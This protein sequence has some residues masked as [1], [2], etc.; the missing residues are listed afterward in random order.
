MHKVGVHIRRLGG[1]GTNVEDRC[2]YGL[3]VP[4]VER[5]LGSKDKVV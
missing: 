5:D 4:S 2:M 3:E 1:T